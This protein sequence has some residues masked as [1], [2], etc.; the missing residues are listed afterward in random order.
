MTARFA[1]VLLGASI[2]SATAAGCSS[3][4]AASGA[5]KAGG[6]NAPTVL[7]LAD[8]DDSSQT[9]TP[10]VRFFAAR[11]AK[12]SHGALRVQITFQ[13][14]GDKIA[15]V[16]QRTVRMV[17]AGRFDLGFVGSRAWDKL[18]VTSLEAL[19]APFLITSYPLLDRVVTSGIATEML[20][21]LRSR[22]VIGLALIPDQLRH[23]VGL[24]HP[25]ASLADFSGARIR[26]VPSRV[27][28]S[29]MRALGAIPMEVAN[30]NVVSVI[31]H[32]EIDG[33]ELAFGNAPSNGIVT[34]NVT[35]FGKALTLFA[36]R[37]AF[38][39]LTAQQRNVI[40]EAAKQTLQHVTA[41]SPMENTLAASF[42]R[43]S[44]ARIV[45]AGKGQVAAL[46]RASQPVYTAL[47]KNAETRSFIAKIRRLRAATP[48][49]SSLVVPSRCERAHR[50]AP[51]TGKLR[52]PSILN[53]TYH[54]RWTIR[55]PM[56]HAGVETRVLRDGRYQW[57]IG[58][59]PRGPHGT[60]TIRG[61]RITFHDSGFGST[62]TF[63]FS[64]DRRGTLHL[65][66]VLP[67]DPGDQWVTAG[68]PWQRV[69]P[70]LPIR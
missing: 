11:V 58:E 2:A 49:P 12:L 24:D 57:A 19:Q 50:P 37:S 34:A 8:S 60:Y 45:L 23:P 18:G 59:T 53:G 15:E 29:L 54:I 17:Q 47:E 51:V 68:E 61:N 31:G 6:S 44:P 66:A 4:H 25:L 65:E 42:C 7:S 21:G 70:P 38:Q 9:D 13:A 63:V 41:T 48:S 26:V 14:A 62:E 39:R 55:S 3:Q 10:A 28:S 22:H 35:F 30:G 40:M 67:M 36:G 56:G 16:E 69:G 64:R 33:E 27:T 5:D 1:G 32:R 52:P 46:V 20:D 43:Q